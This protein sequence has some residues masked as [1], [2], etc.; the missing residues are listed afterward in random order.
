MMGFLV[1]MAIAL[2][3]PALVLGVLQLVAPQSSVHEGVR[4]RLAQFKLWQLAVAVILCG[5]LFSMMSVRE[6]IIPFLLA[7]V[8]VLSLYLRT[9]RDEFVFLMGLRDEDFPGRNDKAIWVLVLLILAPVG[10]WLFRSY[11]LAHWPQPKRT[12]DAEAGTAGA[13]VP[14]A[15]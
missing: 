14:S 9:W 3:L 11:R 12:R 15:S 10:P 5:L 8:I 2:S 6:P 7:V 4:R 1:F 13:T